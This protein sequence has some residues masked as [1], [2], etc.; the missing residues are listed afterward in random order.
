MKYLLNYIL[1][2]VPFLLLGQSSNENY[3]KT[4]NYKVAYNPPAEN[5]A[6][7]TQLLSPTDL[8]V[9]PNGGAS[10]Y[11]K[12]TENVL[13]VSFGG[14]WGASNCLKLGVV[15]DLNYS[16]II[17]DLE[18]GSIN[19]SSLG[20]G[21]PT[22]IYAKI[23]N[24]KLIFYSPFFL[25]Q[26]SINSATNVSGVGGVNYNVN[27]SNLYVCNG[28]GGGGGSGTL[29]IANN[30]IT[31]AA[32]GGWSSNC[33]L[34]TGQIAYLN[35]VSIPNTELGVITSNGMETAY[36]AKIENN[37]LIFYAN[38]QTP[39][40]PTVG[41]LTFEYNLIPTVDDND[42][43]E[44]ISYYDGL[45]RIKQ[46]ILLGQSTSGNDIVKYFNYEIHG[47]REKSYL[48]YV[49]DNSSLDYRPDA[50]TKTLDYYNTP[51]FENTSNPYSEILFERS[52]LMNKIEKSAFPGES[53]KRSTNEEAD[54]TVKFDAQTNQQN[55]VR[56]YKITYDNNEKEKPILEY[57]GFY[58][59]NQLYKIITKDENWVETSEPSENFDH[60]VQEFKDKDGKVI[61]KR[62]FENNEAIDTYYVYDFYGNLSYVIPPLAADAIDA[63]LQDNAQVYRFFPWTRLASV[64]E[65]LATEYERLLL[66]YENQNVQDFDLFQ[67]YGGQGGFTLT[68]IDGSLQLNLSLST[69]NP[70]RL[71]TGIIE[72]LDDLGNFEDREIGRIQGDGYEYIFSINS[73]NLYCSGDGEVSNL[74]TILNEDNR[75]SYQKNYSWYNFIEMDENDR[76]NYDE[77]YRSIPNELILETNIENHW[78]ATGGISVSINENDYITISANISTQSL[79]SFRSG[80]SL[81]LDT[82][83]R[84]LDKTLVHISNGAID[85]TISL[86][87]N[88]V[89]FSGSGSFSQLNFLTTTPNDNTILTGTVN[90]EIIEGLCYQYHYDKKNRIVEKRVPGKDWEYIIYDK[91]DRPI[92][93]QDGNQRLQKQWFFTKYDSF[94]RSLYAGIYTNLTIVTRS[95]IQTIVDNESILNEVKSTATFLN[96]G[97]HLNYTNQAFPIVNIDVN[98]VIYYDNYNFQNNLSIPQLVYD[99]PISTRL[100]TLQTGVHTRVLGTNQWI[101]NVMAYDDKARLIYLHKWD[102]FS[103]FDEIS[104]MKLDFEGKTVETSKTHNK[105]VTIVD[106]Q[107]STTYWMVT[108][109]IDK[110]D[111]NH[112]GNVLKHTQNEYGYNHQELLTYNKYNELGQLIQSKVGGA[113]SPQLNFDQTTS[114]QTIDY[115]Y[116]I[117]GWLKSINNPDATLV[118]DLF[119]YKINY[120]SKVFNESQELFNGNISETHWKSRTDN[121]LRNY[122]YKYDALGRLKKADYMTSYPLAINPTQNEDYTEGPIEYDNNGNI[123]ALKRKG[124]KLNNTVDI[125][126]DLDY[127]Y[128]SMSNKLREVL[129][130]GSAAGYSDIINTEDDFIYDVNGNLTRDLNK[131]ISL[132]TY[133]FLNLPTKIYFTSN[134]NQDYIEYFYD[135][136]GSKLKKKVFKNGLMTETA[137]NGGFVYKKLNNAQNVAFEYLMTSNGYAIRDNNNNLA[138]VYQFKD[139]NGNIRLSY[140][141]INKNGSISSD[142]VLEENNYYPFGLN[143]SGYNNVVNAFSNSS[144]QKIKF[145]G[146]EHQD[147][148]GLNVT[149]MDF[150]Q[151]DNAL[152]RFNVIDR[153]AEMAPS[154]TPYRFAFNNPVYFSDP[155]GLWEKNAKGNWVTSDFGEIA[156]LMSFLQGTHKST[157]ARNVN[158]F[159]LE[160]IKF[161]EGEGT[162]LDEV[163]VETFNENSYA[164]A[165][166]NIA[167]QIYNTEFYNFDWKSINT[168]IAAFGLGNGIKTELFNYTIRNNYKSAKTWS[169]FNKLSPRQQAWRANNTLGKFGSNYLKAA[170]GLGVLGATATTSYTV[171]NTYDYY[172]NGGTD[173]SVFAKAALDTVMTGVGF[174][175]PIGFGISAT[176]FILDSAGA[177]GDFGKIPEN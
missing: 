140:S 141:D 29:S 42:K 69:L 4:I 12:I 95:A 89:V 2:V 48:P 38:V 62:G 28:A 80:F 74:N 24:K 27:F 11:V 57:D 19:S 79:V 113:Y 167:S 108:K 116:N 5:F 26:M 87:D 51:E 82:E 132:I 123:L 139:Q 75:L 44:N 70:V 93:R 173:G 31:L 58:N 52:P 18:L 73:N 50:L 142:E 130:A 98:S 150:R 76:Q 91:L 143:H 20:T 127:S 162:R 103:G 131:G 22:G 157:N 72:R 172:K 71:K 43:V 17:P 112:V 88:Q 65:N 92:L 128:H 81:P 34:K 25:N 90:P 126:D 35:T 156:N 122:S 170:K 171:Y 56:K 109:L 100:I 96:G 7:Y 158:D 136:F 133:N 121:K 166:D 9:N 125:I 6:D 164:E 137:Y 106:G 55:E 149:A 124:L 36:K 3:I 129:D 21:N 47:Q 169:E 104:E 84:F 135:S 32:S 145:N 16:G 63:E 60:T 94:G 39:S 119:A 148:L 54:H 8:L 152:G 146:K 174:L 175:G 40:Y 23:E 110:Y 144:A 165:S 118:D 99:T 120:N 83:R 177:F 138:Y 155:T 67:E 176:Y 59:A 77:A 14:S 134:N 159:I 85:Y 163:T 33:N 53:W 111:Y 46:S 66:E 114:L 147:E 107:Y 101:F 117:R 154:L 78:Q 102:N 115:A 153:L 168:K 15:K 105:K 49:T 161:A 86:V 10:G 37:W 160:E 30:I 151:Y 1:L 13:E 61:L 64:D 68:S 97:I 45:G 41:G